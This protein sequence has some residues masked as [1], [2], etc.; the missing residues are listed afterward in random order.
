ME[1]LKAESIDIDLS[2]LEIPK[3]TKDVKLK[4]NLVYQSR[5]YEALEDAMK[6]DNKNYNIFITGS[7][8][9]GRHTFVREFLN[10]FISQ[11]PTPNDWVYVY[12]FSNPLFPMALSF[13]PGDAKKFK[14]LIINLRKEIVESI[15]HS[16]ES[17][18]YNKKHG[19]F[20]EKYATKKKELWDSL[21]KKAIE[22]GFAVQIGPTGIMTVPVSNGK[23]LSQEEYE[24]LTA[25]QK[26]MYEGNVIKLKR[27]IDGTLHRSRVLDTELKEKIDKLDK[28]I[29]KFAIDPIFEEIIGKFKSNS[30]AVDFI[31]SVKSDIL[32]NLEVFR[33][34]QIDKEKFMLRYDV[35]IVIDNSNTIGMPVVEEL[36]PTYANLFGKV[37]YYATMGTLQTDFRFIRPGSFHRANGGFMILNAEG[38]F[39]SELSWDALKRLLNSGTLKIENIQEYLGYGI[40]A[41][42]NPQPIPVN[43]KII[44]IGEPWIYELLYSYDADFRKFFK[45]KA[46]FDWEL[47]IESEGIE[48][49]LQLLRSAVDK[50]KLLH[51]NRSGIEEI[52]KM[53]M[54][55][56]E[57]RSKVSTQIN[58]IMAL[59]IESDQKA[60]TMKKRYIDKESVLEAIKAMGRRHSLEADRMI[61]YIEKDEIMIETKGGRIGQINGLTVI[62][63]GDYPFGMPV[64][65]VAKTHLSD[66]GV[67]DIQRESN[68]SGKIFTKAV[69][70][71]SSYLSSKYALKMPLSLAATV[72]FEQ[73]YSMIEGDSASVAETLAMI[74][75]I[76]KVPIKQSLAV[77]GSIN[78][79]GE[80]QPVGGV[81]YKI[82][83]FFKVCK[84]KG[85]TGEEGVI[86]PES[87]VDDLVLDPEVIE[88][89][90][91][92]KFHIWTVKTV[93]EAI[94]VAMGK[95][96]GKLN[97]RMSYEKGSV[98]DLVVRE[99]ERVAKIEEKLG[100]KRKQKSKKRDSS[101]SRGTNMEEDED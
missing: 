25:D 49:Y 55:L 79:H 5:A 23:P 73:T 22:L 56:V 63:S 14:D 71:I 98:N 61:E 27:L 89:V 48:Y 100:S 75:A 57:K 30:D 101:E 52:L 81:P 93:D 40:T 50:Q 95:K 39:R 11:M 3:S 77:T 59:L 90:K 99:I 85:F 60:R 29:A 10:Q 45:I 76:S 96:A 62:E 84:S 51:V 12:N 41:T 66:I 34:D 91:A 78:Q 80:V 36:N 82:E 46:P 18:D 31:K 21:N 54:R 37:E 33:N 20:E 24:A 43:V 38:L 83:G 15:K 44:M 74:S 35:N 97:K 68:M 16:F 13:N 8:G 86:I 19:E 72:S 70:I 53:G 67:I 69:L 4:A 65:I 7:P 2:D 87:N 88:A 64:R 26:K 94:E 47:S 32:S 9:S 6:L 58:R 28:E 92:G 42:L 1:E 17:N